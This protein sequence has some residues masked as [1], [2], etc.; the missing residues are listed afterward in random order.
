MQGLKYIIPKQKPSTSLKTLV[1]ALVCFFVLL[2]LT[3]VLV[4]AATRRPKHDE[5]QVK[6][7]QLIGLKL[8][9]AE[10]KARD[11]HLQPN[12]VLRRWDIPAPLGTIVGQFPLSGDT[13]PIGTPIGLELSISDPNARAP[14]K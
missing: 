13:V 2:P 11:S 3:I 9:T 5:P 1:I 14:A 7:P 4:L 8:E 10:L 6:V 12:V